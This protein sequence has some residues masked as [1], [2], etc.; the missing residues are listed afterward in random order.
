MSSSAE[1]APVATLPDAVIT[2]TDPLTNKPKPKGGI[3][4]TIVL[5]LVAIFWISPLV[6]LVITA[7]RPLSDFV[8]NGPL[9][10]PELDLDDGGPLGPGE[11]PPGWS[12]ASWTN[13]LEPTQTLIVETR[14][15]NSTTTDHDYIALTAPENC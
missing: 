13:N 15:G 10:W 4:I 14:L 2:A 6:T 8:A 5:A 3:G 12:L 1:V 7:I 9:S 11:L